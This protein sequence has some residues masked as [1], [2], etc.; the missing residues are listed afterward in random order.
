MIEFYFQR[1]PDD[2]A[3]AIMLED[4]GLDYRCISGAPD[5]AQ[6]GVDS[7]SNDTPVIVDQKPE[8]AIVTR[9]NGLIDCLDYLQQ[10]SGYFG[11]AKLDGTSWPEP[12]LELIQ[13]AR[14]ADNAD[15]H[16]T[17]LDRQLARQPYV[18]GDY[19]IVDIALYPWLESLPEE[20]LAGLANVSLWIDRV[21]Q[22][23]AVSR[24]RQILADQ[25]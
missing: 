8:T 21:G 23:A 2:Y 10:R 14:K 22:R 5:T 12:V 11:P 15:P 6:T 1:T 20:A 13:S 17:W 7:P 9:I 19:S 16:L 24:A 4:A 3:V 25:L 18:S